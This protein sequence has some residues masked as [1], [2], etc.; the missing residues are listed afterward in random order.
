[1]EKVPLRA[2]CEQLSSLVHATSR[3]ITITMKKPQTAF[4]LKLCAG[5]GHERSVGM[6]YPNEVDRS[7]HGLE[8]CF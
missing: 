8:H 4:E 3:K 7:F 6:I 5:S 2:K 1:M